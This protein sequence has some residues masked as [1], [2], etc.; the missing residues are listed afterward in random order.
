MFWLKEG[1]FD[2]RD[3]AIH[4]IFLLALNCGL[5]YAE[6]EKI[7]LSHVSVTKY[8]ISFAINEKIKNSLSYNEYTVEAWPGDHLSQLLVMDPFFAISAWMEVRGDTEGYLFCKIDLEGTKQRMRHHDPWSNKDFVSF[9]RKRLV[10][11]GMATARANLFTGHSL[12]RGC[13]QLL[14]TLGLKDEDI[15]RRIKMEGGRAYL[16]YTEAFNDFAPPTVPDFCSMEDMEAHMQACYRKRSLLA[17]TE[18]F[19]FIEEW[20]AQ[21]VTSSV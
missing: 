11:L 17:D 2:R 21:E 5:R 18:R 16:R 1:S 6:V 9:M 10:S 8:S 14:R 12:K 3:V 13:V 15:M 7:Q 4:A 20:I 19:D